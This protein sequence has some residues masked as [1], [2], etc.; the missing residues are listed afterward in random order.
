LGD[1]SHGVAPVDRTEAAAMLQD[2]RAYKLLE[3]V[4]GEKRRDIDA[5]IDAIVRLSWLAHDFRDEIAEIDVN[6]LMVLEAGVLA[7]DAL[8]VR[9][10][11]AK[12]D[13]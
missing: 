13:S 6:P 7:V 2:L 1:V 3:G 10:A 5:I 9:R 8:V 4:R 11:A 12:G